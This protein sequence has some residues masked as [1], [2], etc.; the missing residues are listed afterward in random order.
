MGDKCK[1]CISAFS[2]LER[3]V[4]RALDRLDT[5]TEK[6]DIEVAHD[7]LR[8]IFQ[9]DVISTD[10]W[11]NGC[12]SKKTKEKVGGLSS[13][14]TY[15]LSQEIRKHEKGEAHD[16]KKIRERLFLD[17]ASLIGIDTLDEVT[18]TC[19]EEK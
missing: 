8:D 18:K 1:Y 14:L 2:S 7:A 6:D 10:L 9:L 19:Q 16:Y 5:A 13:D 4:W 3:E 11:K 12:I 15:D 17:A